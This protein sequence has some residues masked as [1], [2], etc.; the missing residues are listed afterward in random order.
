MGVKT[1]EDKNSEIFADLGSR[2]P[3]AVDD[4]RGRVVAWDRVVPCGVA[5]REQ[6]SYRR[7]LPELLMGECEDRDRR[8]AERQVRAAATLSAT[9]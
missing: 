4:E 5:E 6:L 9:S 3:V 8:R 1:V 2:E 7:F